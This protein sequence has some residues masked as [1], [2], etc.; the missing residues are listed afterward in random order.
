M[1]AAGVTV[2]AVWLPV[3]VP[4]LVSVAVDRLLAGG[5]ERRAEGVD[6]GVGAG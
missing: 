1:V 2:I 3:I 5:L 6:P 4:M